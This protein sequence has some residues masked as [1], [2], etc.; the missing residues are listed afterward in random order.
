MI[1]SMKSKT[2]EHTRTNNL[3]IKLTYRTERE[4]NTYGRK[5][6]MKIKMQRKTKQKKNKDFK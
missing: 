6:K 1:T 4:L 2:N 3:A 5:E